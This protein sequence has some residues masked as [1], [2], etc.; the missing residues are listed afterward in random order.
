M[1]RDT[2][3]S[4]KA[5]TTLRLLIH[6]GDDI[7]IKITRAAQNLGPCLRKEREHAREIL[8]ETA[9]VFP[10]VSRLMFMRFKEQLSYFSSHSGKAGDELFSSLAVVCAL[11]GI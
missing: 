2:L 10:A 3:S 4:S 5:I 7:K 11:H 6:Y 8:A 9:V 1:D